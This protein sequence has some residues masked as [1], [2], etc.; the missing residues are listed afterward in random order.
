MLFYLL[1]P[2]DLGCSMNSMNWLKPGLA[3]WSR[4]RLGWWAT[5]AE[6]IERKWK[7]SSLSCVQLFVTSRTTACQASLSMEFSRQESWSGL[8]FPAP[9]DL[10]DTGIKYVSLVC[11]ALAG[12]F[13]TTLPS[14]K[15]G[16]IKLKGILKN[17]TVLSLFLHWKKGICLLTILWISNLG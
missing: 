7:C 1:F 17:S 11:L 10:P 4:Q 15:P 16:H 6:F 14:G 8:P 9:W 5:S 2:P 3:Q 12:G 13:F